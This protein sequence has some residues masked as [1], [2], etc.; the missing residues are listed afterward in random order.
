LYPAVAA[1]FV[2]IGGLGGLIVLNWVLLAACA[3]GAIRF[4]QARAGRWPGAL[5]GA[6]FVLVS[7]VFIFGAWMTPEVFYFA[8]V[9]GAY[10]L[11]LYKRVAPGDRAGRLGR[12]WTD[13]AAAALL[14]AATYGKPTHALLFAPLLFDL[15]ASAQWKRLA[16]VVAV[17]TMCSVMGNIMVS[18]PPVALRARP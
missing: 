15:F 4:G 11:W 14:G 2:A 17:F 1:P 3:W 13:F 5:I 8:L 18:I 10:F 12:G 9:F 16:G 6:A 7:D